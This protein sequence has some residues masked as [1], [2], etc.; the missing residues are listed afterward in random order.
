MAHQTAAGQRWRQRW[1][2]D[3]RKAPRPARGVRA[4]EFQGEETATRPARPPIPWPRPG[5]AMAGR[6]PRRP[7]WR[8][9][10]RPWASLAH[11]RISGP[12]YATPCSQMLVGSRRPAAWHSGRLGSERGL[13]AIGLAPPSPL[14]SNP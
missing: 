11:W 2:Q 8:P 10:R 4:T 1:S 14:L 12:W 7:T 9:A 5:P 13:P 3:A 6:R